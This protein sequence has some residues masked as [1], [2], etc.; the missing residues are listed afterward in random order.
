MKGKFLQ[1]IYFIPLVILA[2]DGCTKSIPEGPTPITTSITIST[3]SENQILATNSAFV[4]VK[5]SDSTSVSKVELYL[6]D[7]TIPMKTLTAAPWIFE[8]NLTTL[9]DGIHKLKSKLYPMNG[10]VSVSDE[11][12]FQRIKSSSTRDERMLLVENFTNTACTFCKPAEEAYERIIANEAIGSHVATIL[13]HVF[14]PD[15]KDPFYLANT[16]AVQARVQYDSVISAPHARF[17]GWLRNDNTQDF[18]TDW[19]AQMITELNRLP[20][21]GIRVSKTVNGDNVTISSQITPYAQSFPSDCKYYIVVTEDSLYY[22]AAN[23]TKIHNFVMRQM[24]TGNNGK[25]I[26]I[27]KDQPL[28]MNDT[29]TIKSQ[30]VRKYLTAV[31]FVQSQS[32]KMVLQAAQIKIE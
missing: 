32:S 12:N 24:V 29:F 11:R 6:D 28:T 22:D 16:S 7:M 5:F 17:N 10:T 21:V 15:A 9:A 31:V 26:S 23:G 25:A 1:I 19:Q 8:I 13:Y 27:T 18:F 14:W 30:W 3:P 2:F 20:D 4:I